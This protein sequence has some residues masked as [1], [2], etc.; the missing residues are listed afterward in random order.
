MR[1][2]YLLRQFWP[3]PLVIKAFLAAAAKDSRWKCLPPW[4]ALPAYKPLQA[5]VI[6]WDERHASKVFMS[7]ENRKQLNHQMGLISVVKGGV[8]GGV[9]QTR[10]KNYQQE[11]VISVKAF[12][13]MKMSNGVEICSGV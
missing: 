1:S 12:V 7:I 13:G 4:K 6:G 2:S 9:N 5:L 8:L 10:R 3:G 11:M